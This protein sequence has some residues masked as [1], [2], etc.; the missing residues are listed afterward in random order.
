MHGLGL[1][2]GEKPGAKRSQPAGPRGSAVSLEQVLCK[3]GALA[4]LGAPSWQMEHRPICWMTSSP[5]GAN[6]RPHGRKGAPFIA[7][8]WPPR[9][10]QHA[11]VSSGLRG[12][13]VVRLGPGS[14]AHLAVTSVCLPGPWK[15]KPAG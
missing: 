7:L 2:M 6:V 9:C 10:R 3:A 1:R 11:A 14:A 12:V 4:P 15:A 5:A 8:A 13:V